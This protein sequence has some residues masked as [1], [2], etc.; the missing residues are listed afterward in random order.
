MS[1]F[2]VEEEDSSMS[3]LQDQKRGQDGLY[4][5]DVKKA[6]DPKKGYNATI[7]LLPWIIPADQESKIT[8]ACV[9]AQKEGDIFVGPNAIKRVMTYVKLPESPELQ[10]YYDSPSNFG[11]NDDLAKTYFTLDKS[12]NPVMKDRAKSLN[13]VTKYYSY[14][15]VLEDKQQSELEGQIVIFQYGWKI[16]Q[17][18]EAE[19]NAENAEGT[20]CKVYDLAE[21][22]DLKLVVKEVGG[23]ANYDGCYFLERSSIKVNGKPMPTEVMDGTNKAGAKIQKKVIKKEF[24]DKLMAYL[25][26][27]KSE[28]IEYAPK[29]LTDDQQSK[30][31]QII[32]LL[33]GKPTQ[34]SELFGGESESTT[35]EELFG[36]SAPAKTTTKPA[37]KTTTSK[38]AKKEEPIQ[39]E[40]DPFANVNSTEITDDEDPFAGL[41]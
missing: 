18:I 38:P 30:I 15:L 34:G 9:V 17:K 6:S 23:Y 16:A 14:A 26:N 32:K 5:I 39:V 37:A 36:E 11:E 13:K 40:E 27:R 12:P 7:R 24:Q 2:N 41:D 28:M 19:W 8:E 29:R 10:G 20:R 35:A 21:G 25:L 1:L 33:T 3:F 31:S 4:R 22:K